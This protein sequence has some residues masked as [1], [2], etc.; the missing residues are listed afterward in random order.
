MEGELLDNGA[1][2][3]YLKPSRREVGRNCCGK[4]WGQKRAIGLAH[5]GRGC[6]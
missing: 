4:P 5:G 6:K 2:W 1:L 3:E